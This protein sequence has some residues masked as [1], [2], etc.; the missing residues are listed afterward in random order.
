MSR[1]VYLYLH[2]LKKMLLRVSVLASILAFWLISS[3][4]LWIFNSSMNLT[5][6]LEADI[7]PYFLLGSILLTVLSSLLANQSLV[8]EKRFHTNLL[9]AFSPF[10]STQYLSVKFAVLKTLLFVAIIPSFL[11]FYFLG[12]VSSDEMEL[13]VFLNQL[14]ALWLYILVI[15]AMALYVSTSYKSLVTGLLLSL[16]SGFGIFYGFEFIANQI[17]NNNFSNFIASLGGYYILQ[18]ASLGIAN[19]AHLTY[20]LG[21]VLIFLGLYYRR[22]TPFSKL[23]PWLITGPA[24]IVLAL[25]FSNQLRFDLTENKRYTVTKLE[26]NENLLKEEIEIL[27]YLD[28]N[29]PLVF[30]DLREE[31]S[32]LLGQFQRQFEQLTIRYVDFEKLDENSG[33]FELISDLGLNPYQYIESERGQQK[34]MLVFPWAVAVHKNKKVKIPLLKNEVGLELDGRIQKGIIELE[35]EIANAIDLLLNPVQKKIALIR[36]HGES[37]DAL[38]FDLFESNALRYE[39]LTF[40]MNQSEMNDQEMIELLNTFD[41]V[42][43]SNPTKPFSERDKYILDQYLMNGKPM[44]WLIQSQLMAMDSLYNNSGENLVTSVDLN[45]DDLF[46]KYGIRMNKDLVFDKYN[47][48]VVFA[49]GQG[50]Q[51]QY[52]PLP[53]PYHPMVFPY[54]NHPITAGVKPLRLQ[55]A[56][57]LDTLPNAVAKTV[58]LRSSPLSLRLNTP[59]QLNINEVLNEAQTKEI[60]PSLNRAILGVLLEGRFES[61]FK[62]RILPLKNVSFESESSPTQLLVVSDGELGENQFDQGKIV[63]LGY[64]KWTNTNYGNKAFLTAAMDYLLGKAYLLQLKSK[65]KRLVVIQQENLEERSHRFFY[66]SFLLP[67]VLFSLSIA[68]LHWR[69]QKRYA[70]L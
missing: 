27:V 29:L 37:E 3:L 11:H 46:F 21:L 36:D 66:W 20:L 19:L 23:K 7:K 2:E 25:L 57:S 24:L 39:A 59:L 16:L 47:T 14:I 41:L 6:Q 10:S 58:L 8:E 44:I 69:R 15:A 18:K 5:N 53:W 33:E 31:T 35:F 43:V 51:T 42:F 45:L 64:D 62:N 4:F 12:L 38:L 50:E 48:P 65:I 34:R 1:M 68:L 54:K 60:S 22:Q 52:N 32:I 26:L 9:Q 49:N 70:S 40:P 17:S 67:S 63:P 56:N 55:F 13:G 30:Q 61:A 28:G